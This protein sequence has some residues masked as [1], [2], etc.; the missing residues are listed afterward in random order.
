MALNYRT[1]SEDDINS[2]KILAQGDY[3]FYIDSVKEMKSAG[4]I[5]KNGNPKKIYDMLELSLKIV[6]D[7]GERQVRDWIMIIQ[8]DEPLAF[9]LRHLA[10]TCGLIEKYDSGMLDARDF[11][12]K[13]GTA[14]IGQKEYTD[15]YGEVKKLN[16]VLD[17]VKASQSKAEIDEFNDD[18]PL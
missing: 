9:K 16:N 5:D 1:F 17:Y 10:S 15:K 2:M 8:D 13:H 12:G 7:R 18:I 6:T 14:R 3:Q 11:M 4:G